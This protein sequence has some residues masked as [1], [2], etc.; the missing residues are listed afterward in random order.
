M[1]QYHH[2]HLRSALIEAGMEMARHNGIKAL[3]VRE[4][5]RAVGVSANAAYRHFPNH[6]ALILAIASEAQNRLSQAIHSRIGVV[7][8]GAARLRAFGQAYI[9]FAESEPGWFALTCESQDS[10]AN[11]LVPSPHEILL[12]ILDSM[13][14]TGEMEAERRREAEWTCWSV[15]NG[16]ATLVTTGPVQGADRS[17]KRQA[18]SHAIE[19][20]LRGLTTS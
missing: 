10:P 6:R 7:P 15:I 19:T 14:E 4:L 3:G 8:A 1:D 5:T 16:F 18:A 2:G 17:T 12:S 11:A 13:V 9:D 20:L